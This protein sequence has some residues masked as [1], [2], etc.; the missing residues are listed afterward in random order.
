MDELALPT[1][2]SGSYPYSRRAPS[3]QSTIL[4]SRSFAMTEYSVEDSRMLVMKSTAS[5]GLLT[6]EVSKS[7]GLLP[8]STVATG[9][10]RREVFTGPLESFM[11]CLF[12]QPSVGV[13]QAVL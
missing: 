5:C 4:P 13:N 2:S 9:G 6:M 1:T 8:G 11:T 10:S 12:G 3:F 7:F